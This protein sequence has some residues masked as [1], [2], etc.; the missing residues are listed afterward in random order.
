MDHRIDAVS[1]EDR[2]ARFEAAS[3]SSFLQRRA[4][5]AAA[6]AGAE[7]A[8]PTGPLEGSAVVPGIDVFERQAA[9]PESIQTIH[10]RARVR[11]VSDVES[12]A[13]AGM[14]LLERA[15]GTAHEL[16]SI[17]ARLDELTGAGTR[18]EGPWAADLRRMQNE[19]QQL[20]NALRYQQGTSIDGS[21]LGDALRGD[22]ESARADAA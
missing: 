12:A 16:R 11:A 3:M 22:I 13:R 19:V 14:D 10:L 4:L 7:A 18:T 17:L 5:P 2:A 15:A 20:L 1:R 9:S 21:T 6:A 8:T